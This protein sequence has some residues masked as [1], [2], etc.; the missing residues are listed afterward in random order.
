[1][2]D[3]AVAKGLSAIITVTTIGPLDSCPGSTAVSNSR[4]RVIGAFFNVRPGG[5]VLGDQTGDVLAQAYLRRYGNSLDPAG[6]LQVTGLVTQCNNADC[7]SSTTLSSVTLGT[8]N[9]NTAETLRI[10]WNQKK[11]LFNFTRG[12]NAAV[13][14]SYGSLSDTVAP[15]RPFNNVSIRTEVANCVGPT[16]VKAGLSALF[17]KVSISH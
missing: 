5:P 7:S 15:A 13:P 12:S 17:D 4:A 1:M 9:V 8:T 10:D 2:N 3:T 11:K 16:R 6:V 14:A